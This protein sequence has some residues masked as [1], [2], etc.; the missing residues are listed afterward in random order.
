MRHMKK[1]ITLRTVAISDANGPV[2]ART[3]MQTTRTTFK[4][5]NAKFYVPVVTLPIND[6]IK[7][8]DDKKQGI[9]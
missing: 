5:N 3:A 4:I 7:F 1:S 8:L 9:L 2:Q 6:D